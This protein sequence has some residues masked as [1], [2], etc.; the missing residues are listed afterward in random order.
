MPDE[1]G[2][3]EESEQEVNPQWC[4]D[5]G[6]KEHAAAV[7]DASDQRADHND[8]KAD[9][10]RSRRCLPF[11]PCAHRSAHLEWGD[12]N[13]EEADKCVDDRDKPG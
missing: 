7:G 11:E 2:N 3:R 4:A 5:A 8:A 1:D 9:G 12:S 10:T 6:R 13:D